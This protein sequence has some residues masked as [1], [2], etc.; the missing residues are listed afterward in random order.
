MALLQLH[1][2]SVK[3]LK[4]D[5]QQL[6]LTTSFIS[7]TQVHPASLPVKHSHMT[8][9]DLRKKHMLRLLRLLAA[10]AAA[11]YCG[12]EDVNMTYCVH[13]GNQFVL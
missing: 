3:D 11:G 2:I 4:V 13:I 8:T 9:T 7:D 5:L 1:V 10:A 12:D 6:G